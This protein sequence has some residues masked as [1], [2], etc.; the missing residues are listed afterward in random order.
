MNKIA[1]ITAFLG[2]VKNRYMQY[3]PERSIAEKLDLAAKTP[4]VDGVELCYP[5]DFD[6]PRDLKK[7]LG[8]LGLGVSAVNA[9]SRRQGKWI[10]GSFTSESAEE[11][12]EVVDDFK[13]ACDA[14]LAVGT[15]R[16]TTCPLNDGHDYVFE[17]DYAAAY[18][19]AADTFGRICR[20]SPEVR[21]CIEYKQNDPRTRCLFASA[22]ETAAFCM[23]VGLPNLGATMDFGHSILAGERPAQALALLKRTGRLFYVHLNDNDRNWDW[24]ML[25]GAFNLVETIEFF[26][27]L[28]ESGYDG[29][30]YGYDVMS[31]EVDP[32][33][34]FAAAAKLTRKIEAMAARIDRPKMKDI[35]RRRNPVGALS[36]M[37]DMAFPD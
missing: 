25:P 18:D 36:A 15:N 7:R 34:N 4:G 23:E 1:V 13:R 19:Y 29:D 30:W 28:K 2:G 31:K 10:R 21:I 17:M 12:D 22:G 33:E 26:Y 27:H 14:A 9:R 11:R 6:D 8:D 32:V 3:H 20:A 37:Y 35:M 5:M 16:I 24:D